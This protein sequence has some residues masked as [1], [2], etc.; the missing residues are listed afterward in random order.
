MRDKI[1]NNE[2][3]KEQQM[4]GE[5]EGEDN[6]VIEQYERSDINMERHGENGRNICANF[7]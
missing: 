5:Q 1:E 3:E 7:S 2:Q 4:C 6:N